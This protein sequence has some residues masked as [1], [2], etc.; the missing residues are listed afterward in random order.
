MTRP[1]DTCSRLPRSPKTDVHHQV[2]RFSEHAAV[3]LC[4]IGVLQLAS[5]LVLP[6]IDPGLPGTIAMIVSSITLCVLHATATKGWRRALGF[7]ALSFAISWFVEFIGCNYALWFGN[8]HYTHVL[9]LSVGHVPLLVVC[10]WEA[11][12]YPSLLIVDSM[13]GSLTARSRSARL[14]QIGIASLATGLVATA[15]D[16]IGDPLAIHLHWWT[17]TSGGA[18][19]HQLS[20]GVPFSNMWGW[21]EAVFIISVLYKLLFA[22]RAAGPSAAHT[23]SPLLFASA[24]YTAWFCLPAY[25]LVHYHLY[26]PLFVGVFAMVPTI[27][28]CWGKIFLAR[29]RA[30]EAP[31]AATPSRLDTASQPVAV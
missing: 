12:I 22:G 7:T 19:M 23:G 2:G 31:S 29:M 6:T 10:S 1:P 3:V 17:W 24:I 9:G 18:Y 21:I 8:Y 15:W 20:G 25:E 27:A 14:L 28:F 16:M 13:M 30:S 11:L 4:L 5:A 26:E